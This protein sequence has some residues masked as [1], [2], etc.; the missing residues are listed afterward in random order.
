M[1]YMKKLSNQLPPAC[2]C[3]RDLDSDNLK[4]VLFNS[5]EA[6]VLPSTGFL[7]DSKRIVGHPALTSRILLL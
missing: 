4:P 3:S 6:I 2:Q 7:P 1:G 5:R